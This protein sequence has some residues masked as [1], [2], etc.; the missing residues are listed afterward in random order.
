MGFYTR[1]ARDDPSGRIIR[2]PVLTFVPGKSMRRHFALGNLNYPRHTKLQ[3]V[4]V[5][6]TADGW[7]DE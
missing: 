5:L 4:M 3:K 2:K 7:M 1:I 6:I